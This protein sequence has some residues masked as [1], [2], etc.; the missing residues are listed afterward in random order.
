MQLFL[1][2]VVICERGCF[3][4]TLR[5]KLFCNYYI[6]IQNHKKAA[7]KAGYNE[8]VADTIGMKLLTQDRIKDYI[9]LILKESKSDNNLQKAIIGLER[10]AFG[11]IEDTIKVLFS[12][13]LD[14]LKDLRSL[15]LFNIS[16]IKKIKGGGFEIKFFDRIKALEKIAEISK[17]FVN[18][19]QSLEFFSAI[20][21]S[22]SLLSTAN[23]PKLDELGSGD[24]TDE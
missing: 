10:L 14:D 12:D 15:D 8:E 22:A 6:K 18:D 3:Y 11:S 7:V 1:F 2:L 19:S 16:E 5:E 17:I 9:K 23:I 21:K 13:T 20:E 24:F 4:M